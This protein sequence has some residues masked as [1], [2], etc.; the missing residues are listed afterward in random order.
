M[1][2][3]VAWIISATCHHSHAAFHTGSLVLT[4][5]LPVISPSPALAGL[6]V[7]ADGNRQLGLDV[8]FE[9]FDAH[10]RVTT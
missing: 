6:D 9:S 10:V 1:S 5:P 3:I 4:R 8:H 2:E 7:Y